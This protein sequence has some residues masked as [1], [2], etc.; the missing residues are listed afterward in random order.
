MATAGERQLGTLAG[1]LMLPIAAW[2]Q[3]AVKAAVVAALSLALADGVPALL[4][5]VPLTGKTVAVTLSL[6][7]GGLFVSSLCAT[8]LQAAVASLAAF[9]V[10]G[11][12]GLEPGRGEAWTA[13]AP[14][15][16]VALAVLA[17]LN[18]RADPPERAWRQVVPLAAAVG[19]LALLR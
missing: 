18:H 8:S 7:A 3:W 16:G 9:G 4:G 1:Q 17:F 6:A 5:A 11:W 12:L 10:I 2:K 15:A 13:G 14:V 19:A